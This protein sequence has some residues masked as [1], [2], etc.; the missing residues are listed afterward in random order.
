MDGA[1]RGGYRAA[2][3]PARHA[4]PEQDA[5]VDHAHVAV[6]AEGH[7]VDD[8]LDAGEVDGLPGHAR[9][10]AEHEDNLT[11][12]DDCPAQLDDLDDGSVLSLRSK[13]ANRCL[14]G[15]CVWTLQEVAHACD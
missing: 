1:A 8:A 7:G 14:S 4:R 5:A 11:E 6:A 10:A 13:R 12:A 2:H 9:R 3:E 15:H